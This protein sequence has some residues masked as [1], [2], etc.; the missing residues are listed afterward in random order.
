M[1]VGGN[2]THC[3]KCDSELALQSDGSVLHADIAHQRETIPVALRKLQQALDEARSGNAR[4]IRLV[5][6]RGLIRDE[7]QRQL[8]WLQ[9]SGGVISYDH[10]EDNT[11]AI[12]IQ[13]RQGAKRG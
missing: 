2:V 13:L 6:G 7:V 10:D 9:H 1:S 12:V 5:V 4:A 3:P 11:G 8:S